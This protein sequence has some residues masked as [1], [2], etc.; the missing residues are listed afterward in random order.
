[1]VTKR[2]KCSSATRT[3]VQPTSPKSLGSRPVTYSRLLLL[4]HCKKFVDG[5]EALKLRDAVVTALTTFKEFK[6]LEKHTTRIGE[7]IQQQKSQR[8]RKGIPAKK[9][10]TGRPRQDVDR[11][12]VSDL[13]SAFLCWVRHPVTQNRKE[14]CNPSLF[15][16]FATPILLGLNVSNPHGKITDHIKRRNNPSTSFSS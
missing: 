14:Q 15:E 10:I 3:S 16:A 12:L 6:S 2:S 7:Q 1:M 4:A 13:A 9:Q 11:L 5:K 8:R